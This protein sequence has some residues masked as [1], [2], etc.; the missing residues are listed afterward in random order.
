MFS[1]GRERCIRNKWVKI[2]KE[3]KEESRWFVDKFEQPGFGYIK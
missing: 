2:T 1:G 3:K